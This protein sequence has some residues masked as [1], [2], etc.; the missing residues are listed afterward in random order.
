MKPL[1]IR[2]IAYFKLELN[3]VKKKEPSTIEGLFFDYFL[4]KITDFEPS[5]H[6]LPFPLV[7]S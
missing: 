7:V 6:C 4:I 5:S 2:I 3:F 1:F